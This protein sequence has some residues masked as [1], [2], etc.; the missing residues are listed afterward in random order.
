MAEAIITNQIFINKLTE[1]ILA[2]LGNEKFGVK[3]LAQESGMSLYRMSRKLHSI[4][5]KTVNQ[6]I[7][8]VRLQKALEMLKNE[9]YTGSE[10]AYKTGFGSPAYFFKCFHDLF[11]YTPGEVRGKDSN[12]TEPDILNQSP[13]QNR[14]GKSIWKTYFLTFPGIL[15]PA[16]ILVTVGLLTYKKI[17]RSD[18]KDN[19]VSPDGRLSIAVMPFQNLTNDTI[20]NIWQE[21]IQQNLISYLSNNEEL[22]IRQKESIN[23]LLPEKDLTK[24]T[25]ISPTVAS[26]VSQKLEADI[27][28]YGNIQE[29]GHLINVSAQLINTKTKEVLKSF[30]VNGPYDEKIIFGITDTLRK[31]VTDFLLISKLIKNHP[32]ITHLAAPT[33]S[34]EA[35]RYYIY[36]SAPFGKGDNLTAISWYLKALA[37]DSDYFDPM[38]MISSAYGNQGMIEQ[39]LQWVLKYYKKKDQWSIVPQLWASWAYTFNFEPP[40]EA[41]R[42]LRQLHQI[43][44]QSPDVLYLLGWSYKGMKQ[45]DKAIPEF[46]KSLEIYRKWGKEFLKDNWNYSNLGAV[47]HKTG[48]FKKEKK[49]V[50]EAEKYNHDDPYIIA[51]HI[52]MSL[53]EKDT[54]SANRYIEK[55]KSALKER[56]SSP[57]AVLAGSLGNIYS[58]E[59]DEGYIDKAEEYYYKAL[60][61]EPENANRMNTFAN[62]L[63]DNN[64]KLNEVPDLMDR[65]MVFAKNKVDYYNYSDMK[66]WSL[67]KQGKNQEALS[68]LQKTWDEAPFKLYSIY[69]HLEE[70]KRESSIKE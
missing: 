58:E 55:L 29:A 31:K 9:D 63:V 51:R 35:L 23:N 34:P 6:F 26:S 33:N 50:K 39:D 41:I 40:E 27:F 5:K 24:Y 32:Y 38:F 56:Y 28:I 8:E 46:E 13:I 19:L 68:I 60:S 47:Y 22:K 67:Y 64:R 30:E 69:S 65:A 11:G 7:R 42:C 14:P 2:N 66:G 61:L 4:N 57:E 48:Q 10:V 1:I 36:G 15:I 21:A 43:D 3:E 62:F 20:W 59:S 12:N 49:L 37:A 16:L 45:Y 25:S 44:D 52:S 53:T 17:F 70:V 18:W 54:I